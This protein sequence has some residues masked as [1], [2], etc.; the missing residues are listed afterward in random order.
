MVSQML[1]NTIF[2]SQTILCTPDSGRIWSTAMRREGQQIG[3][4]LGARQ[5]QALTHAAK[6]MSLMVRASWLAQALPLLQLWARMSLQV[7]S[8]LR[9]ALPVM[10]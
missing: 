8:T 9:A 1:D 4:E 6:G 10:P 7:L 5:R 2:P 3:I